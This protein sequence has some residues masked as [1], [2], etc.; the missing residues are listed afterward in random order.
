VPSSTHTLEVSPGLSLPAVRE[1]LHSVD[2][3]LPNQVREN[4]ALLVTEVVSNAT[5]HGE[6]PVVLEV[7]WLAGTSRVVV[8]SGGGPFRWRGPP[9]LPQRRGGWG[10]I[11]VDAVADRWGVHRGSNTN[12][13]WFEID[14]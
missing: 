9:P 7:T 14:H 5:R 4:L 3:H 8:R 2:G 12:Q 10:L 1:F 13:V 6:P 11:F